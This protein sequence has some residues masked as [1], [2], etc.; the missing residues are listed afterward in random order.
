MMKLLY[1]PQSP[2]ARKARAAAIEL[3]LADRIELEYAEVV[4]GQP[5]RAF[6]ESV[7]PLRKVPALILD[8]GR[9]VLVDSTVICE[10]LDALAGGGRLI[11]GAGPDRWRVL[12]QHAVAQGMCEAI[13]LVRY[14]T[15]LR[16][17]PMRWSIWLDDQW[18]KIWSGLG[19]FERAAELT[20]PRGAHTLD[21]SHLAL[22]GCLGYVDFRFPDTHWGDRFPRV[23]AWYE[24]A[25]LRPSLAQTKPQA[26]PRR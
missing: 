25:A 7:N 14:E 9:T 2:F 6:A 22:A 1:A 13:I 16:P 23:A 26:P 19:W 21:I 12:S 4:P 20:V 17:E 10:F 3:G 24:E 15:W 11:P 5:N 8:D 18:D